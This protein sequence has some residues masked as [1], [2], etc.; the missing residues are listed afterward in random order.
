MSVAVPRHTPSAIDVGSRR[1]PVVVAGAIANASSKSIAHRLRRAVRR[2]QPHDQGW[3]P[4]LAHAAENVVP[5][6][7]TGSMSRQPSQ[8]DR[9]VAHAIV[10]AAVA[11]VV[12]KQAGLLAGLASAVLAMIVHEAVDAPVAGLIADLGMG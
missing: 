2:R 9:A 12:G 7:Q 3:V 11:A 10:G 5:C 4:P 6:V 1:V 8:A